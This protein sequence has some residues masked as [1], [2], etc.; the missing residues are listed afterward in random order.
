[1]VRGELRVA[2]GRHPEAAEYL[3]GAGHWMEQHGLTNPA[4]TNWRTAVVPALV[5]VGR[6]PQAQQ[7]ADETVTRARRF[8]AP[9]AVGRALL[10][11]SVA[12]LEP[13]PCR[14]ERSWPRPARAPAG[15]CSAGS[16][17]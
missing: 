4:W 12:I 2:Q 6:L 11:E 8:G 3:L 9:G 10:R 15:S 1:V 13:S 5:A 17:R 14:L 7:I 16:R